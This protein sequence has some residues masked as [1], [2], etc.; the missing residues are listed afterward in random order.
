MSDVS[1]NGVK[2]RTLEPTAEINK[3]YTFRM[4]TSSVQLS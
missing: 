2:C 1:M 3:G 4:N